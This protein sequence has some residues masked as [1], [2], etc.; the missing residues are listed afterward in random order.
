MAQ[1][2]G[3]INL[4]LCLDLINNIGYLPSVYPDERIKGIKQPPSLD[5][6]HIQADTVGIALNVVFNLTCKFGDLL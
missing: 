1:E 6:E 4:S 2:F 3:S 5:I